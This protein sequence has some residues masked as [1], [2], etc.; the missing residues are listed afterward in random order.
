MR[1]WES[2]TAL[3]TPLLYPT[4]KEK[5]GILLDSLEPE[6]IVR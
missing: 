3:P 2:N 6:S 4:F 5:T 1:E